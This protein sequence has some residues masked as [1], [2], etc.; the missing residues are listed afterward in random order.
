M[1]V[2]LIQFAILESQQIY[3]LALIQPKKHYNKSLLVVYTALIKG[4]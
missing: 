3:R 4:S 2:R 1:F